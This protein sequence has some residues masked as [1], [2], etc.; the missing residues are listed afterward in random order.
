[1]RLTAVVCLLHFS[2]DSLKFSRLCLFAANTSTSFLTSPAQ[3]P[4]RAFLRDIQLTVNTC[5]I[6]PH[7]MLLPL[8]WLQLVFTVFLQW[9][10]LNRRSWPS[11]YVA[12]RIVLPFGKPYILSALVAESTSWSRS[13]WVQLIQVMCVHWCAAFSG[14]GTVPW[15]SSLCWNHVRKLNNV[16]WGISSCRSLRWT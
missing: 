11:V 13:W 2:T 8:C 9:T 5:C 7:E 15:W 1:M 10:F 6:Q 3:P 16:I 4:T 14:S 12:I